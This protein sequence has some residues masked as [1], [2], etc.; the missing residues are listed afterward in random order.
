MR[1][2]K[3]LVTGL[4]VALFSLQLSAD[5]AADDKAA[6]T[7]RSAFQQLDSTVEITEVMPTP[8]KDLY[9]VVIGSS[10][11]VYVTADGKHVLQGDLLNIGHQPVV[12]LTE[13]VRSQIN[14]KL[15][16]GFPQDKMI[17][18]PAE[19]PAKAS[20]TVFTD[21]DCGYCRK[22][23]A[24]VPELNALGIE[25]RYM[26]FPRG[27]KRAP[28][29]DIMQNVWCADD[30]RQAMTDAKR[31][32]SIASKSCDNPVQEEFELGMQ[33][34]VRGTPALFLDDGTMIPGYR[35]AEDLA[36]D[37]GIL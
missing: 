29:Y 8:I 26:A 4:L 11:L 2:L 9:L 5:Q 25:V 15:L 35:P 37:L 24:E 23:H 36:R 6:E 32:K 17:V 1:Q 13:M 31:G 14:A 18:F 20:I 12:N 33:L 16:A 10:N 34:G 28:A 3:L 19:G 30:Q 7:I 27:G 21:V 22:L